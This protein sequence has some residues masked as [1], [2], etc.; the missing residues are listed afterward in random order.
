MLIGKMLLL[1]LLGGL[2]SLSF[3]DGADIVSKQCAGCHALERPDYD[4]LGI[5]ERGQRKGPP[6]YYAGNKYRGDWLK[7]WLQAPARIHPA[8][9]FP[10]SNTIATENG[11]V[12]DA[13]ALPQH[14]AL[15]AEDADSVT[16]YL[17]SL[18]PHDELIAGEPYQAG[19]VA[20]R[21]GQLDFRRFKGCNACHQD[22]L[23]SGGVSGPE[24]YTAG[25]R[26]DPRYIVSFIRNP[27]LWDRH[28]MMPIQ[29]M[30]DAAIHKLA[31][32]LNTIS[33]E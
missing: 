9:Y 27:T 18:R 11:D 29:E 8:G 6:L 30:N 28:S 31:D 24:L 16:G 12:V 17:M 19:T 14:M 33:G 7:S 5:E 13:S 23:G 15:G 21:M 1:A 32:Y 25:D 26:L 20:M 3:A 4:G 22:E 2:S 10:P